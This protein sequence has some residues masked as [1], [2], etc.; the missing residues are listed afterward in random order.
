MCCLLLSGVFFG[1]FLFLAVLVLYSGM[2]SR[3]IFSLSLLLDN[4]TEPL[5]FIDIHLL[6]CVYI[7]H[8]AQLFLSENLY[9]KLCTRVSSVLVFTPKTID[10]HASFNDFE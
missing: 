10:A 2:P 1:V 8:A 4:R 3:T 6:L 9:N 5:P 7:H